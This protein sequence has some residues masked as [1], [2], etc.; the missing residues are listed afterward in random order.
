MVQWAL[1]N[2]LPWNHSIV[3]WFYQEIP[4][5]TNIQK[6]LN[7]F[8]KEETRNYYATCWNYWETTRA[9]KLEDCTKRK[10]C[11]AGPSKINKHGSFNR[12]KAWKGNTKGAGHYRTQLWLIKNCPFPL[13]GNMDKNSCIFWYDTQEIISTDS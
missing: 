3:Q 12:G 6:R 1:N 8:K 10:M 2:A 9:F 5:Q 11:K 4:V 13:I 7:T